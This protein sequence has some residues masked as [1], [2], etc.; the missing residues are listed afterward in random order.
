VRAV[1]NPS[2]SAFV[3]IACCVFVS[4]AGLL[5]F[6][7][8]M[9]ADQL[10]SNRDSVAVFTTIIATIYAVLLAFVV[11]IVWQQYDG[12]RAAVM[13]EASA[14]IDLSRLSLELPAPAGSHLRRELTT[15]TQTALD[16]EW[17]SLAVGEENT[18][19]EKALN[20]L[21]HVVSRE[22]VATSQN[23]AAILQTALERLTDLSDSR[24]IC[25]N[26]S[27]D[28][29]PP[30]LWSLLLGGAAINIAFTYML[31]VS[32]QRWHVVMTVL[33]AAEVGFVLFLIATLDNPFS[34]GAAI[35]QEPL[36]RALRVMSEFR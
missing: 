11:V 2:V 16:H 19:T 4:V 26:A 32:S 29:M 20:T 24:R 7:R 13:R 17:A 28:A 10:R 1:S 30:V 14:L 5:T 15:F 33:L 31:G 8:L 34:A 27:A 35:S 18:E 21:W 25:L 3:Y 22:T 6:R 12:A 23:D 36:R 9:P